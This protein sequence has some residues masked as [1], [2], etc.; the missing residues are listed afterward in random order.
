[1]AIMRVRTDQ[2]QGTTQDYGSFE[3]Q[4]RAMTEAYQQIIYPT[5]GQTRIT[6][7]RGYVLGYN[8]LKVFVNGTLQFGGDVYREIDAYTIEFNEPLFDTDIVVCRQEGGGSG[9]SFVSDHGHTYK[10]KPT[11]DKD[12]IN[13]TF[14]I[15]SALNREI[16]EGSEQVFLNGILQSI[17]DDY[18]LNG[19]VITFVGPPNAE[20]K[21]LV[22]YA[23]K[24]K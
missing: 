12:G 3:E 10:E 2:V 20:D 11:G 7:D 19:A 24:L 14:T 22:N 15:E 8:S 1:M 5:N 18:L 4:L 16:L 13:M 9:T 17:E 21:I 23:Y 6:L